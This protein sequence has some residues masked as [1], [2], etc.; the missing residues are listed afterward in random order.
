MNFENPISLNF[1]A[2]VLETLETLK[3]FIFPKFYE[4]LET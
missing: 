2:I 1:P 3:R 4:T